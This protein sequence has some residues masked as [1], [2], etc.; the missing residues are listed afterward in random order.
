[1]LLVFFVGKKNG[2]KKIVIDYY[3][4]NDQIVKNNYLLLLI[5]DLIDNIR[6]K[7][8]F[9]KMDLCWGFDNMRIKKEDE[10]KGVFTTHVRS[11]ELT[12]IVRATGAQ[13]SRRILS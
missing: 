3:S 11:F 6:S 12:V 1:M 8:V 5:M 2:N 10:Q 13:D 9:T 4:L 7:K